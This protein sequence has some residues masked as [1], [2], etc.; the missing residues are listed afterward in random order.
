[1]NQIR[2]DEIPT[3]TA[4]AEELERG[5]EKSSPALDVANSMETLNG[6]NVFVTFKED[7]SFAAFHEKTLVGLLIADAKTKTATVGQFIVPFDYEDV[8]FI[9]E[10]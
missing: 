1:M 5:V 2:P 10:T 7:S 6:R 4:T 8:A 3:G 9:R